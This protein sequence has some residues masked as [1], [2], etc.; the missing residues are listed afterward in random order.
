MVSLLSLLKLTNV[1]FFGAN[2]EKKFLFQTRT[3]RRKFWRKLGTGSGRRQQSST[4]PHHW[5]GFC[6]M[7]FQTNSY[8]LRRRF[9]FFN[10]TL[11]LLI[12]ASKQK[13]KTKKSDGPVFASAEEVRSVF[14]P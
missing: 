2:I 8:L 9:L 13:K 14:P 10:T 12:T 5:V 11:L 6:N 3:V 1:V 7:A 4:F